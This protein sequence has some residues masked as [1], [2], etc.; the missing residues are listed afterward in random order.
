VVGTVGVISRRKGSDV[1][2]A[3]AERVRRQRPGVEFRMIGSFPDDFEA[4][5]ARAVL[6]RAAD[7]GVTHMAE[8]DV[9]AEFASWDI[10]VLPSR[11]DPF[12]LVVLEAMASGLPVVGARSDGIPEQLAPGTGVLVEPDA[13]DA[14]A[15]AIIDLCDDPLQ[16]QRIG[17]AARERV[18]AN[19]SAEAQSH[20]LERAYRSTIGRSLPGR[21]AQAHAPDARA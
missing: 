8:A 9:F 15:Q 6:A 5:W 3:A 18:A 17:A 19:F 2:V 13:P 16:R 7:A 21:R 12:P 14:L 10:F 1:F 11:T 20:E 4:N